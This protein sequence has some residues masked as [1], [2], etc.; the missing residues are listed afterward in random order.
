M[1][2]FASVPGAGLGL[3]GEEPPLS[4]VTVGRSGNAFSGAAVALKPIP[5]ISLT[6][7]KKA[8]ADTRRLVL[9]LLGGEEIELATF[10]GR[11]EAMQSAAEI[12]AQLAAAETGGDW[13]EI[14]GRFIRP[15]SIASV[16]VLSD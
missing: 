16:D 2:Q 1:H 9:R 13:P 7:R 14:D 8:S 5:A 12:V 3:T 15:G 11:E 6:T 10:E 4:P